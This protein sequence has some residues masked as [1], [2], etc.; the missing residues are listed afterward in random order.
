MK[1]CIYVCLI[2]PY[3][4]LETGG[5]EWRPAW[6]KHCRRQE[7]RILALALPP[8]SFLGQASS[9]NLQFCSSANWATSKQPIYVFLTEVRDRVQSYR[10]LELGRSLEHSPLDLSLQM[11]NPSPRDDVNH[12]K[13]RAVHTNTDSNAPTTSTP[14]F[15]KPKLPHSILFLIQRPLQGLSTPSWGK[16]PSRAIWL[17]WR[18]VRSKI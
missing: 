15:P 9:N 17:S 12:P 5:E 14:A 2:L 13:S 6:N 7:M 18:K 8:T 4:K 11:W 10:D 3:L 16:D 1:R